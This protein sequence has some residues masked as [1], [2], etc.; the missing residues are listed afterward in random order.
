MAEEIYRA[1]IKSIRRADKE[2]GNLFLKYF[3]ERMEWWRR[4]TRRK[5]TE[6]LPKLIDPR[7]MPAKFLRY[8]LPKVGFGADLAW[9][10]QGRSENDLRKLALLACPM[11]KSLGLPKG[12][13]SSITTLTGRAAEYFPWFSLRSIGGEIALTEEDLPADF[14]VVGGVD[15]WDDENVSL[16][17]LMDD[18]TLDEDLLLKIVGLHRPLNEVIEV[19]LLDFY[20]TFRATVSRSR[21]ETVT[22]TAAT[23]ANMAMSLPAGTEEL[24]IVPIVPASSFTAEE[25]AFKVTLGTAADKI[26]ARFF[27][28]GA[29]TY[30]QLELT[31]SGVG[32][33][34]KL[35]RFVSGGETVLLNA[36]TPIPLFAEVPYTVRVQCDRAGGVNR[37]RLYL[38]GNLGP[39]ISDTTAS[40]AY[41][42]FSLA[43][44]AAN[45]SAA[46]IDNVQF[47]RLP[48]R[49]AEVSRA[50]VTTTPNFM[51]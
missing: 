51:Q 42:K 37:L 22:G 6:E 29:T 21:W 17:R 33:T 40:P 46:I 30:Y 32:A 8:H 24:A 27:R 18:G 13:R 28:E 36:A 23:M 43:A 25:L 11:W 3:F 5:I 10:T 2:E 47:T 34:W 16:L 19:V 38:D 26:R 35:S 14:R 48:G 15:S 1:V 31:A 50:G 7:L 12:L 20:D 45:V 44:P 41:G 4:E 9:I 49:A 39:L